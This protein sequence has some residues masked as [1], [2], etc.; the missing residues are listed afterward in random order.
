MGIGRI[1]K[2]T[3]IRIGDIA[4][5]PKD[6]VFIWDKENYVGMHGG[7]SKGEIEI[8]LLIKSLK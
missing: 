7:I 2:K 8:P 1:N 3:R 4:I 6:S 5:L